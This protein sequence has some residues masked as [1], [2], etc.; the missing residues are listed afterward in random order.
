VGKRE[1]YAR[2]K[3][4]QFVIDIV[5]DVTDIGYNEPEGLQKVNY[6]QMTAKT[7]SYL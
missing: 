4:D 7:I 3:T 1:G 6:H 5:L 2:S